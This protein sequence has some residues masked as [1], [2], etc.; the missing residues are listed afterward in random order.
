MARSQDACQ[1]LPSVGRHPLRSHLCTASASTL[2]RVPGLGRGRIEVEN[3]KAFSPP[4]RTTLIY[5][6]CGVLP[7]RKS[8]KPGITIAREL[9]VT[10]F[11]CLVRKFG[12]LKNDAAPRQGES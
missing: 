11:H 10:W 2:P 1:L 3:R 6:F 7:T 12:S 9:S 4:S 5:R 8:K